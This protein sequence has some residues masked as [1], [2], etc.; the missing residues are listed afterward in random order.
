V[1]EIAFNLEPTSPFRQPCFELM[2]QFLPGA[3]VLFNEECAHQIVV[4]TLPGELILSAREGDT[5]AFMR[6]YECGKPL[7]KETFK[8]FLYNFLTMIFD[9]KLAWGSLTGIKP[10]KI[11]HAFMVDEGLSRDAAA[12]KMRDAYAV[13]EEKSQL[14]AF[15]ADGELPV[16]YPVDGKRV[17]VYVGVPI[18]PA[19]CTYC[20]FVSTVAD[21]K[22][23]LCEEYLNNLLYEIDMMAEMIADK[24][25]TVD[26][27]YI[28]GGTPSILTKEQITTLL[29]ALKGTFIHPD[30]R[31]FTFEAG[32]PETTTREKLGV[33]KKGGV[34]RICLNPQSMNNDTL[35]AINRLHT[36][37]DILSTYRMIREMGF[38]NVNMDL[39]VG[40]NH[41]APEAFMTSLDKVIALE[42]ENLTVHSLAIKKGSTMKSEQGHHFSQLYDAS[43]YRAIG[44]R[45]ED[46]GYRPYYLYRQKYTQGNGENIGYCREGHPGIYNIL[47]MA[48]KQSII[49]IGA[50]SSGKIYDARADRFEK[51]FTV[52]DVRTYNE[53][54]EK[55]VEAK[56][57]AYQDL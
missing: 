1:E 45:L 7:D 19:R 24:G 23:K 2:Q 48:E 40:L 8:G 38:D 4:E 54:T 20:S 39:I 29:K 27:L 36:E 32:R 12:Q 33:L 51:V 44:Q 42:P 5:T 46:A 15:L 14:A 21:K 17:S 49:G 18:C 3:D 34:D 22:G 37:E 31:E 13:S 28:G 11:A 52:K 56:L 30:L 41:E 55:I 43:F 6:T 10:V 26:T 25:L 47:M 50:G 16:V 9:K 57:Q 35:R 53:R